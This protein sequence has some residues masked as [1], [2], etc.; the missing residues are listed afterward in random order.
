[1]PHTLP[2]IGLAPSE[3]LSYFLME[4]TST[5][6]R[7]PLRPSIPPNVPAVRATH[8]ASDPDAAALRSHRPQIPLRNPCPARCPCQSSVRTSSNTNGPSGPCLPSA[9]SA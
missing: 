7:L 9:D 4:K 5:S 1:T 8:H 3:S 6:W 2:T